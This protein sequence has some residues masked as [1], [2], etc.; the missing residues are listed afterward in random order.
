[1]EECELAR[2]PTGARNLPLFRERR[3]PEPP[4]P[5]EVSAEE[6]R[7]WMREFFGTEEP[8]TSPP[9]PPPRSRLGGAR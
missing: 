7:G 1:M 4:P 5:R 6:M 9:L 8:R 3:A 2:R